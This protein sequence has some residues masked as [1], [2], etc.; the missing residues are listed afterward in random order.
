[1][2]RAR[3]ALVVIGGVAIVLLAF[4]LATKD[5]SD[6]PSTSGPGQEAARAGDPSPDSPVDPERLSPLPTLAFVEEDETAWTSD[7]PPGI[8]LFGRVV[9]EQ[10][11]P[12]SGGSVR[13]TDPEGKQLSAAIGTDSPHSPESAGVYSLPGL[14][15]GAWRFTCK[16]DDYYAFESELDLDPSEA[17][18]RL[19]VTLERTVF[20]KVKVTTPDG[21]PL[22]EILKQDKDTLRVSLSAVATEAPPSSDFPPTLLRDDTRLGLGSFTDSDRLGTWSNEYVGILELREPLPAYVSLVLRHVVL[23]T[24]LVPPGSEEV[25]FVLS[26]NDV[27]DRLS[28]VRG[29]LVDAVTGEPITKGWVEVNDRQSFGP[30]MVIEPDGTFFQEKLRPGLM[31]LIIQPPTYELL[32]QT[33]TLIPGQLLDLGT[34][35]LHK[36]MTIKGRVIDSEGNGVAASVTRRNL[37]RTRSPEETDTPVFAQAEPDGTFT[38][39]RVGPGRYWFSAA[40]KGIPITVAHMTIT[41]GMEEPLLRVPATTGKLILTTQAEPTDSLFF[42]ILNG[43]DLPVTS[44][45]IGAGSET[46][47]YDL[48]P[49][50]YSLR[51]SRDT[52]LL[53]TIP[54]T[55][56]AEPVTL[57]AP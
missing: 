55:I 17:R 50:P 15:P 12:V 25:E 49:G 54:F 4:A 28:G 38:F 39:H 6:T 5:G 36:G 47:E 43:K 41:T 24:K 21:K 22:K 18:R 51:I 33:I 57:T 8:L 48:P 20:L 56:G 29:R 23:Q 3:V 1:M 44:R 34:L 30:G 46:L 31:R 52:S 11:M 26:A 45:L 14:S 42:Q 10:G 13:V 37:N 53:K 40:A 16:V 32:Q 7:D 19:D 35:R 9:D 27:F 2:N